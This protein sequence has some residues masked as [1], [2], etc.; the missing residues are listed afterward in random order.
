MGFIS[1][2]L[3]SVLFVLILTAQ[4]INAE[5]TIH[6]TEQKEHSTE[7]K[8][9]P[10][11]FIFEHIGDGYSWHLVTFKGK[12]IAIPLP[13]I[14]ISK[15]SGFHIFLSSKFHHGHSAYNGFVIAHEGKNRGKIV[16]I[17]DKDVEVKPFD[18]SIT[19]NVVSI[20]IT[21]SLML[22]IFISIANRYKQKP[23]T[24]PKGVQSM[25][26]PLITFVRDDIA[27]PSIGEHKYERYMPYLLTVFFFVWFNNML[28]LVP[29]FPGGANVTGN[30]AVTM[31]LAL[32]TFFITTFSGNKNYWVHVFNTPGVPWWLKAIPVIPLVEFL[33]LFTK[34]FALMIR[35]FANISAGHIIG[36]AFLSLIFIFGEKNPFLGGGISLFVVPFDIFMFFLE[37]LVAFIQAFVFTLLSAVYFG[38]AVEEHH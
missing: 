22:W 18:F 2:V 1:K 14:L 3:Y 33:S 24:A 23:L 13:V 11:P 15:T 28:G 26:E 19:K 20:I 8:F 6:G 35:L 10:G 4:V 30:I 16:E 32:F 34:P 9:E 25:F 21:V 12:D 29:F 38:M 17:I 31:V 27:I 37:L 7:K 36:L 5:E